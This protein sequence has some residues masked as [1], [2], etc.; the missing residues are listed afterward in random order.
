MHSGGKTE[1]SFYEGSTG[2]SPAGDPDLSGPYRPRTV[3][4]AST[5]D[6]LP[7]GSEV[8]PYVPGIINLLP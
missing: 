2:C 3:G 7:G 6:I 1:A 5:G 8:S 4:Q